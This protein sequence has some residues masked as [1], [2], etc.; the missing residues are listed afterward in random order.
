MRWRDPGNGKSKEMERRVE[1]WSVIGW[2]DTGRL[3]DM[4]P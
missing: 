4:T 2:S 1:R 3:S